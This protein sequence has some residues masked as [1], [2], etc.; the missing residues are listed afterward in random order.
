MSVDLEETIRKFLYLEAELLDR[1]DLEK[2]IDLYTD[3]G[4]YWMPAAEGQSDPMNH[5]SHIYD[6]RT[7]MEIR[8]RYLANPRT[9]S[10]EVP[11]RTSHIIGNF[12][13]LEKTKKNHVEIRSNFQVSMWYRNSLRFYAGE[14]VHQ[15]KEADGGLLIKHKRVNLINPEA[16]QRSITIYI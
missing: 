11:V 2:W 6:D 1:A 8:R 3:D 5:I 10:A 7:M 14:Y 13:N 12:R 4:T 15:L 16:A 9:S